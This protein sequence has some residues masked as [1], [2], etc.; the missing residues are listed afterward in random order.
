M[1]L[2]QTDSSAGS[3]RSTTADYCK[4]IDRDGLNSLFKS[5]SDQP[6]TF[7]TFFVCFLLQEYE[8]ICLHS[9]GNTNNACNQLSEKLYRPPYQSENTLN[10]LTNRFQY[11]FR[12]GHYA[13][14]TSYN[15]ENIL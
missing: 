5:M 3:D 2:S 14:V 7:H 13:R 12:R 15:L 11:I 1:R 9:V 4:N 6:L 10:N 8:V